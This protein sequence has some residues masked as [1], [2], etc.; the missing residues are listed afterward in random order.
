VS[1][2]GVIM[3]GGRNTRYGEHKAL[4]SVGGTR[5][6]ERV[7]AALARV[8]PDVV[9]VANEPAA[10]AD[11]GLEQRPDVRP[12][13]GA[14]GGILTAV[15]WARD[16]G[17]PGALV[18]ACDMPFVS[19]DL[20][21]ELVAR[22]GGTSPGTH[23]IVPVATL[24]SASTDTSPAAFTGMSPRA[25]PGAPGTVRNPAAPMSLPDIVAAESG[26]R[27]GIEPL[28][29][30]YATSCL[31]AIERALDRGDRRVIA[32]FDELR[33]DQ[34]PL[35][36]VRRFGEPEVLFLNVNTPEERERAERIAGGTIDHAEVL[37]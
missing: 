26:G 10:Y 35:E 9:L 13:A 23:P 32:F 6:L 31:S 30:Y 1:V 14:L 37:P 22:T 33:V 17:C 34:M 5:I 2:L 7:R 20:L 21:A 8:T 12:G 4:A 25:G 27:R 18:V 29:A 28:C 15:L 24:P 11:S 16:R 3:A 36:Q 19:A